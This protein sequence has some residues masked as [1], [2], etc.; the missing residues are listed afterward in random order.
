M[1]R[2]GRRLGSL[3]CLAS[4]VVAGALV[5][6]R[7]QVNQRNFA[8]KVVFITG[9]SRGLGLAVADQ[10]LRAGAHVAIAARDPDELAKAKLQLLML[11]RGTGQIVLDVLCNV[12][13]PSSVEAAVET[14]QRDLGPLDVLVNNAGIM[15]VAPLLNQSKRHFEE[16]L[17]TN[18]YGAMHTTFAILPGMLERRKGS[19]VNIAS[20]GGLIAVPHML[21]YTAS[22]FALV[23]FS[24][25]LH[26]EVKSG[27]VNVLTVCPWLMRTGSHLHAK[28]GGQKAAEYGW[29]SLGATLPL[30]A[31]PAQVAA[32]QIVEATAKGKSELLISA[33]A[34]IA[35][36]IAANAPTWTAAFLSLLNRALPSAKLLSGD[37]REEGRQ[38]QGAASVLPSALGK[39]AE[40]RWNQ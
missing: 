5:R 2:S 29:F 14:V 30:V 7:R 10:F 19:I 1:G 28:V 18:F 3:A 27:G 13:D 23:G 39:S 38:I 17:D 12:T 31:I 9:G 11:T 24:R 36:K 33:W 25:G 16:A 8:G 37:A 34:L 26:A 20:I 21:P 32:R 6:R 35:A 15:A 4:V 40:L 22:K